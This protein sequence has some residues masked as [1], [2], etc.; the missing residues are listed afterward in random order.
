MLTYN[1]KKSIFIY[2]YSL[3]IYILDYS[4]YLYNLL[5]NNDYKYE[6]LNNDNESLNN[7]NE[8]LNNDIE[9]LNNDI[10]SLNN[11]IESLNNIEIYDLSN[12]WKCSICNNFNSTFTTV[13]NDCL[14]DSS[15]VPFIYDIVNEI[16]NIT[17]IRKI[18]DELIDNVVKE[19][20]NLVD[21]DDFYTTNDDD[22]DSLP[23]DWECL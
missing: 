3:Y 14:I 9:S 5:F 18:I 15:S 4:K 10:E 1:S 17:I 2:I 16:P 22:V 7:D 19:N 21:N 20:N 8:S 11:D 23:S 6:S 13:C 12:S